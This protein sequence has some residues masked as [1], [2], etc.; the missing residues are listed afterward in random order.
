[1]DDG[2]GASTG[3]LR[4]ALVRYG[5][6]V[7]TVLIFPGRQGEVRGLGVVH[8]SMMNF[9]IHVSLFFVLPRAPGRSRDA[10]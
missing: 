2:D 6:M 3:G 8:A 4:I 10:P 5:S 7:V 9:D 1:M